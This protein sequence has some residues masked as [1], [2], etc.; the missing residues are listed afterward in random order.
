MPRR[1]RLIAT[2]ALSLPLL[3]TGVALPTW[4]ASYDGVIAG[5][6]PRPIS[7]GLFAASD[8]EQSLAWSAVAPTFDLKVLWIGTIALCIASALAILLAL[9]DAARGVAFGRWPGYV[10]ASAVAVT[11]VF[12]IRLNALGGFIPR[13]GG[14]LA[15][16][17]LSAAALVLQPR[18]IKAAP[19]TA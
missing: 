3:L 15:I 7:V 4:A 1:P 9:I 8:G 16:A 11:T 2:L 10:T 17:G 19:A 13:V 12:L 18:K 5:I 6:L 14:I